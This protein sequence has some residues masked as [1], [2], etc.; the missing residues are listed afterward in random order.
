MDTTTP[1]AAEQEPR[2]GRG[3]RERILKAA[4]SLFY[5]QGINTTGM[6]QLTSVAHVSRRTFYQH[7]AGKDALVEAYL[8]GLGGERRPERER[9]LDRTG[10]PPRERLLAVFADPVGGVAPRGCPVHNAAVE[11]ADPHSP[12]RALAARHKTE[13]AARLAEVAAE[14]GADDPEL[15][16]RRLALLFEGASALAASL[17]DPRAYGDARE[18]A[19]ALI[20]RATGGCD[21]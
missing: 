12:V 21:G 6:D 2:G 20:E 16:G 4:G 7:F 17:N 14:A 1:P 18:M 10:T 11:F 9:V 19:R 3:A 5:G 15:L 13:F 8:E